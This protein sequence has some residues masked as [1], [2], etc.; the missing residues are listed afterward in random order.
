MRL[1]LKPADKTR[2]A[3]YLRSQFT[4]RMRG[5]LAGSDAG[6]THTRSQWV[7]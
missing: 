5:N 2:T 3:A 6:A 4:M 1:S 7:K